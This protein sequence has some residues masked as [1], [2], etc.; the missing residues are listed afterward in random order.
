M[1]KNIVTNISIMS[2]F[3]TS[4]YFRTNLGVAT[5]M[6]RGGERVLNKADSFASYYYTRYRSYPLGQGVIGEI[7]FYVDHYI[8]DPLIA[9]YVDNQEFIFEYDENHVNE[10]GINHYIG[11]LLMTVDSR[12]GIRQE[13]KEEEEIERFVDTPDPDK[14][15]TN[16][17]AVT[18]DDLKAFISSRK[19]KI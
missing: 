17:G 10:H 6:E 13:K 2:T 1:R 18:Y 14:L 15:L 3:K 5:T 16:P 12:M 7:M 11:H 4:P 19:P 8:K 9:M